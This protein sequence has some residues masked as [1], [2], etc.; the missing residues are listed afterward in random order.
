MWEGPREGEGK[1]EGECRGG[2]A[3][4][5][6]A[7]GGK[8]RERKGKGYPHPNE[9]LGYGLDSTGLEIQLLSSGILNFGP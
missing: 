1:G 5:E 6:E 7:R 3:R 4:G 9:N 8:G 2:E